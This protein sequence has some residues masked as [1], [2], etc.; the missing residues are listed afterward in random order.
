MTLQYGYMVC[1]SVPKTKTVPVSEIPILETPQVYPYPCSTLIPLL[2]VC[3]RPGR[4][5]PVIILTLINLRLAN[6]TKLSK[7][8][9]AEAIQSYKTKLAMQGFFPD[10]M[11]EVTWAKAAWLD[12]CWECNVKMDHNTKL[13]KIIWFHFLTL[14]G[15]NYLY[16]DSSQV[17]EHK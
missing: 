6:I 17:K 10:H 1:C 8:R 9:T 5:A 2:Q 11:E 4:N 13:I 7:S 16:S 12:G 14:F 3:L 15:A